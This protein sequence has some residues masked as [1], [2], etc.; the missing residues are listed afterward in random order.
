M[1]MCVPVWVDAMCTRPWQR[2]QGSDGCPGIG[3]TGGCEPSD[4]SVG[5]SLGP[6]E[7]QQALV[8]DGPLFKKVSRGVGEMAQQSGVLTALAENPGLV[9]STHTETH[10]YL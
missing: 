1:C 6:L 4:L 7:E 2:P 8:T 9:P 10:N 5:T 3:V